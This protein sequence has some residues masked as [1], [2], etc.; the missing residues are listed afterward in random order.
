MNRRSFLTQATGGAALLTGTATAQSPAPPAPVPVPDAPPVPLATTPLTTTPPVSMAPRPDG[1]ELVWGVS[2]HC[3]GSVEVNTDDG[4]LT[5]GGTDFGFSSQGDKVVRVRLRGLA[6]GRAHAYRAITEA[7]TEPADRHETGWRE[8]R[9]LDP[10]SASTKVVIWNDTHLQQETLRRLHEA[11]PAADFLISNGDICN[12]WTSEGLLIPALLHPAGTDFTVKAP[13]AFVWGNHD[14]RG[15]HGFRLADYV[16]TPSGKSYYAIRSGPVAFVLLNTGEDKPDGHPSFK[17]R[18]AC[19]PL[20]KE[21]AAWL[22]RDILTDPVFRDAPYRVV[23]CHIPLRWKD[24]SDNPGREYDSFSRRSRALWHD[25]LVKWKAQII[26]SGHMH[27]VAWL[28]ASDNF[29]YS[30]ITGGGPQPERS[31]WMELQ[32]DAARLLITMRDLSGRTVMEQ[33]LA[34]LA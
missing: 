32:A 23:V 16:A 30:Q 20:R 7:M 27:E 26:L 24:E 6:P 34:P 13:L 21:Q 4:I 11:T 3:K 12:D 9:T 10:A 1:A 22:E 15:V 2:R 31:T 5:F 8:I 14:L 29:P 18:V 19:E 17:G 33:T 25:A 28:P